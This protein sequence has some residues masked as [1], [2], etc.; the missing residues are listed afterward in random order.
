MAYK[1]IQKRQNDI[2]V[3]T[4]KTKWHTSIYKKDKM[5]Y[6]Y[7]QKRQNGIQVYTKKTPKNDIQA[8]TKKTK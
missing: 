3:Y 1:Y 2:Q 5:A 4:K 8:Y 6:K 7:I